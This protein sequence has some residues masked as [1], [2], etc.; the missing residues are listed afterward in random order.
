VVREREMTVHLLSRA[1]AAR[2]WGSVIASDGAT[3]TVRGLGRLA[4]IGNRIAVDSESGGHEGEIISMREGIHVALLYD[5]ATGIRDGQRAWLAGPARPA[6]DDTWLGTIVDAFGQTSGDA[7]RVLR[8]ATEAAVEIRPENRRPLGPR[9]ATGVAA[10]DTLVPICKGQR[11]GVFAGSGVGKSRLLSDLALGVRADVVVVGLIGERTREVGEFA[12]LLDD[13]GGLGRT[14]IVAATG[15]QSA[16]IKRR[17]ADLTLRTA[18]HFRDAGK[19][20]LCLFD[21]VTRFA[22]AHREIAL[23][24]GEPPAQRAYPPSTGSMI[25]ALAERTG[26]GAAGTE[27]GD[28]TA[29]FT[30]LVAGS[31]M[32][33]PVADMVRGILDGH[34]ILNREIA[35]RG[36]FPAID[37]A[38]S[39]SRSAPGAWSEAET[40]LATKARRVISAYESAAPMI[41]AGLY[42]AGSDPAIDE[43]I[44]LWPDLDAFI[45][46]V[47]RGR[48]DLASFA[49]L[50]RILSSGDT[51]AQ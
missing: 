25:S 50:A 48:D 16:L 45:G 14:V 19:H 32:E 5:P 4:E 34:V 13:A 3:V 7:T 2:V 6:P 11:I 30:V 41:R 10:F 43:A 9:L 49:E 44:A 23:A 26:P 51:G 28:I 35:E 36:R 47:A 8:D 18:E 17:A 22:E 33:E 40:V 27:M 46:T 12:R 24:A 1:P 39:V 31:D 29:I 37:L 38:R 42:A 20:V 21:S 15:D